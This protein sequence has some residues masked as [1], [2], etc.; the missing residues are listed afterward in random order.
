MGNLS[1]KLSGQWL[2]LTKEL[3][4]WLCVAISNTRNETN[5]FLAVA[6]VEIDVVDVAI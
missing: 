6:D 1:G 3:H 2:L 4:M 5:A